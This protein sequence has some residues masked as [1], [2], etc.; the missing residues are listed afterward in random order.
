MNQHEESGKLLQNIIYVRATFDWTGRKGVEL[1][2]E[3]E[4][5]TVFA[6]SFKTALKDMMESGI[7]HWERE[8]LVAFNRSEKFFEIQPAM[9]LEEK[10]EL[11]YILKNWESE[12]S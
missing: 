2:M 10:E 8:K 7:N 1:S 11:D 6:H 12:I 9:T 4:K 5:V 3:N